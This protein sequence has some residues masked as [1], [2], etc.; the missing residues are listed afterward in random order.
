MDEIAEA[1]RAGAISAQLASDARTRAA[2]Q[3]SGAASAADQYA[4]SLRRSSAATQQGVMAGQQFF[5]VLIQAQQGFVGVGTIALQQGSQLAAQM[6]GLRAAGGSVFSTL[7]GGLTSLINPLSLLTIGA[8]AA[9]AAIIKWFGSG[10]AEV[11]SFDQALSDATS[12]L[13]T[14]RDAN[15][16]IN[17][18]NVEQLRD[19]YGELNAE[20]DAHIARMQQ[21]AELDAAKS[22]RELADPI[23]DVVTSDFNPLTTSVDSV[24]RTFGTTNGSARNFLRLLENIR[25]ARTFDEQL[26]A[27]S[28]A[29]AEVERLTGGLGQAEGAAADVATQLVRAE[30]LAIQLA[31][32]QDGTTEAT[33]R[34]AGAASVLTVEIGSAAN[35]AAALLANLGNV[36]SAIASIQGSVSDQIAEINAAN[37]SLQIQVD[38]GLTAAAAD[39]TV[40]LEQLVDAVAEGD[41]TV[42]FDQIAD[43]QREINDLNT[44]T[45]RTAELRDRLSQQ[46]NPTRPRARP[47]SGGGRRS[48]GGGGASSARTAAISEEQQAL[49]RLNE[50]LRSRLQ[51]LEAERI[52]MGLVAS[53]QFETAEAARLMAQAMVQSGG[54]VDGQTA[55]MIRQIDAASRLN[56][57]LRRVATDPVRE[58]MDSVPNWIEAGQQ[59]EIGAINHLKDAIS[60]F[61]QTGEFDIEAL[62]QAILGT[63]ADIVADKAVAELANLFG[64][65]DADSGGLGGLLGG[66]FGSQGDELTGPTAGFGQ[67]QQVAQGGV[68]AGNSISQAMVQA[69]QQVSQQISSAMTQGGQQAG[70]A[71]QL[72]H[73]QGGQQAAN[74]QRLAGIQHGQQVRIATSTSGNQHATQVR[75]A[76]Q[77]GGQQHAALVRGA[78]AGGGGFGGGGGLFGTVLSFLPGLFAEGGMSNAPV[79]R[80]HVSPTVFRN[81]PQF[82][83]GTTNTSGIPAILHDNEAVVP[84]TRG[85]RIPVDMSG[86]DGMGGGVNNFNVTQNISTPDAD[87]FRRSSK[88][89]SS[90]GFTA[91]QRA[92]AANN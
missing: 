76:I 61:V 10:S 89:I 67:G 80:A 64:R 50:S 92:A 18:R 48:S 43:L 54:A 79:A 44:A 49:D 19:R 31:N 16:A 68:Q 29:R 81:A 56:E 28:A 70:Q 91:A 32:A 1:E 22:A 21:I 51:S 8:V 63:I 6:N 65:G 45:E 53:G 17:G 88:Q 60:Q 69:G 82:A 4:V 59:I 26:A 74:A 87:S 84:L 39:R 86:M 78:A 71:T 75:T 55:A 42:S 24:R 36:P 20:L 73:A 90:D 83:E 38:N 33:N 13:N 46:N 2:A 7:L 34:A 37:R 9:G 23:Q 3:L 62:G 72:A 35:A 27:I 11:K 77:A 52:E 12:R 57:E 40:Q 5:D 85:R 14:L 58:W 41:Q 15:D 47:S 30:D 66:L 25:N